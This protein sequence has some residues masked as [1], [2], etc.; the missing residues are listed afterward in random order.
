MALLLDPDDPDLVSVGSGELWSGDDL[1]GWISEV[2][3]LKVFAIVGAKSPRR[4]RLDH[5]DV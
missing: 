5:T 1:D 4:L 2:E 3:R